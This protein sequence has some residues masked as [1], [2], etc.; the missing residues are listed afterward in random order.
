MPVPSGVCGKIELINSPEQF[1]FLDSTRPSN[2]SG[3]S[4]AGSGLINCRFAFGLF[5]IRINLACRGI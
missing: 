2:E 5:K 4:W 3:K 1:I